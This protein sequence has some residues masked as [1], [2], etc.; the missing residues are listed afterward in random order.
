[1]SHHLKVFWWG[2]GVLAWVTAVFLLF[3]AADKSGS[4]AWGL[5]GGI[6]WL[7]SWF[8]YC[9]FAWPPAKRGKSELLGK[10]VGK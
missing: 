5:A 10:E 7:L 9:R 1:M 6:Y 8:A 4:P 3:I 2:L